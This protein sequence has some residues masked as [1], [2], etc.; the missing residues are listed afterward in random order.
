MTIVNIL[1]VFFIIDVIV[2][3]FHIAVQNVV[4]VGAYTN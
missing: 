2:I 1:L 3:F 4:A